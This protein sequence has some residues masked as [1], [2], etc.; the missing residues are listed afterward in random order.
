MSTFHADYHDAARTAR[1]L[2]TRLNIDV[3]IKA[4]HEYGKRG[5]SVRLA[6]RNDHET[7]EIIRPG[8][9]Q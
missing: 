1:T 2:A 9:P 7:A 4:T 3:A 5:F 6:D 8:E